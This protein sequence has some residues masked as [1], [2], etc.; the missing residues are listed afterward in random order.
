MTV[1]VKTSRVTGRKQRRPSSRPTWQ[2]R[3][4]LPVTILK[5]VVLAIVTVVMLYPFL[6]VISVSLSG[7]GAL[8]ESGFVLFPRDFSLDAYKTVFATDVVYRAT[9]I[10][11][12]VT[13]V[14]TFFS[15]AITTMLAYGLTRTK[16]VP[17]TR[18]VLYLALFTM[19]FVAGI[20]PNYLLVK[21]LGLIDTFA[22]LIVPGL[23]S[24][25]NLV[26]L[27]NF[28]MN[29][30][31]ELLDAAR[32]DGASEFRVLW[33]IVLPLSKAILAV[34]ALFYGVYYW[35]NF[36]DALLYMNDVTKWPIQLVLNQYVVQGTP[37]EQTAR[38]DYVQSAAQSIKMAVLVVATIPILIVYPF[39]Q[40]Y[41]A[42]GVLTGAIKQ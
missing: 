4:K 22:A 11:V 13:I 8:R 35:G 34:I 30:P 40:R 37:L 12:F 16:D 19:L 25:F 6:Y 21:G 18:F 41:F 3:P 42:S 17:G 7:P 26:V 31:Q 1:A 20:I 15:V 14:G 33:S 10:S 29:M 2:E 5:F 28:F 24:A 27:R 36:F 23:V 9:I 38:P 39:L 32:M